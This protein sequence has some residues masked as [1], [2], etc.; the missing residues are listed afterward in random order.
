MKKPEVIGK[1]LESRVM[2]VVP[3][4]V[5][6]PSPRGGFKIVRRGGTDNSKDDDNNNNNNNSNN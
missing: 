2:T 6:T 4:L 5:G 1:E 3:N